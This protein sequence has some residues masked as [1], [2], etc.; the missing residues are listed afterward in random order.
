MP[1]IRSTRPRS[2]IRSAISTPSRL[3]NEVNTAVENPDGDAPEKTVLLQAV[4]ARRW[5]LTYGFG[6]EAQTGQPQN[7]CA[8]ALRCEASL[9]APTAK[10]ASA[11]AC[12]PTITRNDL[13]GREQSA[14]L[15]GTYGL[16]EQSIGLLYQVPHF[17]GNP[18][19]GFTFSGGYAN[20][21]D[22]STY[23][24]SRLE[25]AFRGTENFN[26]PGS[27][28]SR[29]NTFIYEIDFRRVKVAA[30]SLQ[31]YPGEISELSTATRVGGPAFTWIRDTR[32]VPTGCAPRHLHQL[33]GVSLRPAL[34]RAGGVQP[35]R[36]LEFQLLQLR[37]EPF[38]GGAQYALRPDSRLR[39]RFERVDSAARAAL[40]RRS[41]F[42]AR[43]LAERRRAR[44]IPRPAT[45]SAARERLI[46]STELRLPPPTLPWFGNTDQ[47]RHLS[48][49]GQRVYQRRRCMGQRPARAPARQRRLQN[50]GTDGTPANPPVPNGP[51]TSTGQQGPCSFND[52]SHA[53]GAGLRYHTPVGPIRFDFSYNLNPPIYP[54]NINYSI[55]TT[56][57]TPLGPRYAR[58]RTGP[59]A[60]HQLLFQP[61]A[62]ILMSRRTRIRTRSSRAAGGVPLAV[63]PRLCSSGSRSR[64]Q[65]RPTRLHRLARRPRPRRRRRQQARHPGQRSR[66]RDSPLRSRSPHRVGQRMLTRQQRTRSIDQPRPHR[67]ADPPGRHAGHRAFAGRGRMP[68]LTRSARNC[69]PASAK[70]APPTRAGRHF[71][72][73]MGS[74]RSASMLISATGWRFSASSSS[75]SGRAFKSRSSRSKATTTTRCCRSTRPAKLFRRSIRWRRAFRRFCSSSRSMCCSTTG[76]RICA[77]R[78]MS[79]CS[80]RISLRPQAPGRPERALRGSHERRELTPNSPS[81]PLRARLCRARARSRLRR[82]FLRHLPLAPWQ[83]RSFCWRFCPVGLYFAASSAAFENVVRKRLIASIEELTGGRAEIASFHWR[84]LH[85]EAEADGLVIHGTGRSRRGALRENRAPAR[86]V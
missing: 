14:S 30:S 13:F 79:K 38:R 19:F 71:S 65:A 49:H 82:F 67:A 21:E 18:N 17:E 33:S 40:C 39:Q 78:A 77:S 84:L 24:A 61:G 47:L 6:F 41:R 37:Q 75:D 83:A 85:F 2:P 51:N 25:G 44:A 52:F 70:T 56:S 73:R 80:I 23:V 66:R 35:H 81:R 43:F 48:R 1:A 26:R 8:G 76:S 10:P 42:A 20:S 22:V 50:A 62:G 69:P 64:F 72:R 9:A 32:D 34:R 54:V 36:H 53:L 16:L 55:P 58:R 31:V 27:W 59:G 86:A 45:R 46:N 3:F 60:A 28:L 11:R 15:R 74:R 29:A 5:T 4:E 63:S 68:G 7:N 12:S 57:A